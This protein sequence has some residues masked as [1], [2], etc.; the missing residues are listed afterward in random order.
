MTTFNENIDREGG[1]IEPIQE[2]EGEI[3][4]KRIYCAVLGCNKY[5]LGMVNYNVGLEDKSFQ[6]VELPTTPWTCIE[7]TDIKVQ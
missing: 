7:H 1:Y 5:I 2:T 6:F 4:S 3:V